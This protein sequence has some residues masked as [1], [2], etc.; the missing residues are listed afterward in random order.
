MH[1]RG[2][3]PVAHT[4]GVDRGRPV[5]HPTGRGL[6]GPPT[7]GQQHQGQQAHGDR[8]HSTPAR[9][10]VQPRHPSELAREPTRWWRPTPRRPRRPVRRPAGP[11][12][13]KARS[14]DA[15]RAAATPTETAATNGSTSGTGTTYRARSAPS[16]PST[17]ADSST[18]TTRPTVPSGSRAGWVTL[19]PT[20]SD[21]GI[22]EGTP[23]GESLDDPGAVPTTTP[24]WAATRSTGAAVIRGRTS[25][26][27]GGPGSPGKRAGSSAAR[28]MAPCTTGWTTGPSSGRTGLAGRR[29]GLMGFGGRMR[30]T[31]RPQASG[32]MS[33]QHCQ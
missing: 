23:R 5:G 19:A 33:N 6:E 18:S 1:P 21:H 7:S 17:P 31:P 11:R 4:Q 25:A 13:P 20:T 22:R 8:P 10:A 14:P 15:A 27:G 29:D 24:H 30:P 32:G 28:G 12:S 26:V 16:S 3:H 2:L 9:A